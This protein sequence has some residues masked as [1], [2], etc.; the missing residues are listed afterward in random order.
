MDKGLRVLDWPQ[1]TYRFSF[2]RL[3][4]AIDTTRLQSERI[5]YGRVFY[6]DIE[7]DGFGV[8]VPLLA[9]ID[10]RRVSVRFDTRALTERQ[11]TIVRNTITAYRNRQELL[12]RANANRAITLFFVG[13]RQQDAPNVFVLDDPRLHCFI[14][15]TS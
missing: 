12:F 6:R 3:S 9:S 2:K 14:E 7:F 11:T 4:G 10:G 8:T 13:T 1:N 5:L 15:E